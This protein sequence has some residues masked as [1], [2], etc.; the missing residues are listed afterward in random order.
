MRTTL[1]LSAALLGAAAYTNMVSA[2]PAGEVIDTYRGVT[3]HGNGRVYTRSHG[4]HYS[5]TKPRYYYGQKWQC[6]EYI[7]RFYFDAFDHR[8]PDVWGHAI[9]FY[10]PK[11]AHGRINTRRGMRQYKNGENEKPRVDDLVVI[12]RSRYGHVAVISKVEANRVQVVQQNMPTTREWIALDTSGGRYT[13][14]TQH[15]PVLGWLRVN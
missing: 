11:V 14:K 1:V 15:Y 7:K 10:D 3:V 8:M 6:V 4:R 9:D 2:A 13:L 5:A 12:H